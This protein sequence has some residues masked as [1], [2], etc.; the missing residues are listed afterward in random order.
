MHFEQPNPSC[1]YQIA[2]D[3]DANRD[4]I[5]AIRNVKSKQVVATGSRG[6]ITFH[7]PVNDA[8]REAIQ[9]CVESY[10]AAIRYR[11]RNSIT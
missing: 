10:Q 5:C 4:L 2:T 8:I 3:R 9:P 6:H 1:P 7:V 11:K